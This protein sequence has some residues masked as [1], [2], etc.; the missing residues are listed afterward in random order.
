MS[1]APTATATRDAKRK[2]AAKAKTLSPRRTT[3]ILSP[4]AQEI[5]VRFKIANGTSTSAAIDQIIQRSEPKPSR[6]KE[7]NGF[8]VLDVPAKPGLHF[9]LEDLKQA[10][11]DA[12]REYVERLL[13]PGW[14]P[15]TKRNRTGRE[16]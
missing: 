7:V 3:I 11:D 14:K 9:T 2:V 5:V 1:T 16:K 4:E 6:L 13:P 12:D 8:L 15:A 10:E